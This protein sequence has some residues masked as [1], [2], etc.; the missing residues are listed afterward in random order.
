MTTKKSTLIACL[1]LFCSTMLHAQ[2]N[3]HWA[4]ESKN[5]IVFDANKPTNLPY[6]DNIE[7]AGRRVA[8]IISYE[9]DAKGKLTLSREIFFPQLHQFKPTNTSSFFNYRAYLQDDYKDDLLP[10]LYIKKEQFIPGKLDKIRINGMLT[11]EHAPSAEGLKLVRTLYPSM[12]E[13][14]FIEQWTLTNTSAKAVE[15]SSGNTLLQMEDWGEKGKFTRKIASNAP[16]N[17]TLSPGKSLTFSMEIM[18]KI[19]GEAFPSLTNEQ[20]LAARK[21]YIDEVSSA[22]QIETPSEEMNTL[23]AFSKIRG[24]E[25]IFESKY[26]LIHSPGGGRYYVGFWANDQAEYISPF[27][28]YL[29]YEAG[30]ESAMNC[31]RA[32]AKEINP[33]YSPLRYS[34]EVEGLPP[35][36][37]DRGDAAMIAYGASHFAMATGDKA[38]AQELWTLI[39]WCLEY[40]HR[41]RNE[42]GVIKSKTDEMEGR[43]ETGD[44][45]LSTSSLYYGALHHSIYLAKA[46]HIDKKQ[47]KAYEKNQK[48]LH[49]AIESYFG[50]KVEG[51][52]TYK[53]YKEH[54]VLRH[55][56]CLPLVVGIFDRQE[57]TIEALF[58]R[59]W[60]KDGVHVER[61]NPKKGVSDIF[62]DRGTL[63][64][65]RG[66]F[67]SGET[68]QSYRRL[69]EF[70]EQRLLGDRVPYVVEAAPE[71]A[72]AHLSAESGLYCRIFTEGILGM[73]PTSLNSFQ[74]K[75]NLP[76][77]W[78]HMAI[79]KIKAYG[80]NFDIEVKRISNKINITISED[81]KKLSSKNIK[82]GS[83][84]KFTFPS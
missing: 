39:E 73:E 27:F 31:Y 24:A 59:L 63:Y 15:I 7:M 29:G 71:G 42:A 80:R 20:N 68:E 30:I 57:A 36:I 52:D 28:P 47:I 5:Q 78:N 26:G 50:S 41:M 1:L 53:Y 66:A 76:K 60:T 33:E 17:H 3:K 10:K 83:V 55:W 22:L 72:M 45:N 67:F 69:A 79:R 37:Q 82:E 14:N 2:T 4:I 61:N 19:D 35:F 77:E 48:D 49:Q 54:K 58:E 40:C 46:L 34:F 56:I 9:I 25:S 16:A 70:T 74:L 6:K 13:R 11:F 43:I 64:A 12:T 84:F 51:L 38:V 81:G 23:F 21:A 44:A 18:A 62:W 32:F 65:L 75:P 8:G